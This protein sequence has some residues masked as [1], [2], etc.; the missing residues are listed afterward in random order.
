MNK[1]IT[2]GENHQRTTEIEVFRAT[3]KQL[4][5]S[6]GLGKLKHFYIGQSVIVVVMS[7][8][9]AE[10]ITKTGIKHNK[11]IYDLIDINGKPKGWIYAECIFPDM[12]CL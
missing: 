2:K 6:D 3:I 4:T 5:T 7:L 10:L 12:V 8:R 1:F 11:F 9:K